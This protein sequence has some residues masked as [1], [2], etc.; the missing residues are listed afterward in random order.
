MP[1]P[2]QQITR[3]PASG[4]G[5]WTRLKVT[6]RSG[7][8]PKSF[9]WPYR[10]VANK[11]T[12]RISTPASHRPRIAQVNQPVESPGQAPDVAPNASQSRRSSMMSRTAAA[13]TSQEPIAAIPSQ[14]GRFRNRTYLYAR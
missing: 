7:S 10:L 5:S 8:L 12:A 14:P 11:Q 4:P 1:P 3:R 13:Q 9:R 6:S 2:E